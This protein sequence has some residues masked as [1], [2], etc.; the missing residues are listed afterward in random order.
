MKEEISEAIVLRSL[1]F[2]ERE[3]LLT[4]FSQKQ[5]LL[6]LII[7]KISSSSLNL[8]TL[9]SPFCCAEYHFSKRNSDIFSFIDAT[10]CDEHLFL[11]EKYSHLETASAFAEAILSSQLPHKST[12]A[13]YALLK[14]FLR[15]IPHFED[16]R[17][18][19]A[20][21]YL[22]VLKHEGIINIQELPLPQELAKNLLEARQ[23]SSLKEIQLSTALLSTLKKK[24]LDLVKA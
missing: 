19:I 10:V 8:F 6:S 5:G 11:R 18:L 23:F 9:S 12:P 20:S 4:L 17:P 7:K 1:P 14:Q 15:Q 21:F 16:P 13:L 22:K 24:F 2:K 3:R